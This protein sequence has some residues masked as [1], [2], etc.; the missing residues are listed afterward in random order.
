MTFEVK[1][2]GV[3]SLCNAF[4]K[5]EDVEMDLPFFDDN[6][7]SPVVP[8][9]RDTSGI[10][11]AYAM[12]VHLKLRPHAGVETTMKE[13]YSK[14]F[15]RAKKPKMA[16]YINFCPPPLAQEFWSRFSFK[17]NISEYL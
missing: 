8:V 2:R 11:H 6:I 12:Y 16:A 14:M 10:F 7:I 17:E 5:C 3:L 1:L 13:I 4:C 9:V 15:V